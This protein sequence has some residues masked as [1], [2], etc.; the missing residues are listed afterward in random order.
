MDQIIIQTRNPRDIT[1]EETEELAQAIRLL[2]PNCNVRVLGGKQVGY[3]ITWFE[4]LRIWLP[5]AIITVGAIVAKEII[6]EITKLAIRW[7]CQRLKK[8]G[9]SRRPTYIAIYGPDGKILKSVVLKNDTDDIED[10]T[11]ADR[12]FNLLPPPNNST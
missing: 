7:A 10:H 9:V 8:K 5:T 3:G 4:I 11:E 2:E 6:Q 1:L 12:D